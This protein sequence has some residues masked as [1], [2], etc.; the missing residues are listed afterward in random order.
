MLNAQH[1]VVFYLNATQKNISKQTDK[2]L[3]IGKYNNDDKKFL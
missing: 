3:N 2:S 1:I